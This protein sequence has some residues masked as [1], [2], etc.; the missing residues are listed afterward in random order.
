VVLARKRLHLP[1]GVVSRID[2]TSINK[3][4]DLQKL[5]STAYTYF[6][7]KQISKTYWPLESFFRFFSRGNQVEGPAKH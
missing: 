5:K 3:A 4:V 2:N 6:T 1:G 7:I